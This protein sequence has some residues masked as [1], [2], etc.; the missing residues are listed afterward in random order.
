MNAE[1][2]YKEAISHGKYSE[3]IKSL[4]GKYD[5]VRLMWEDMLTGFYLRPYLETLVEEK[6]KAGNG[7][8]R[9][10]DL[11]CG[12]GDGYFLLS[13]LPKKSRLSDH[14]TRLI[15]EELVEHYKGVD[16]SIDLLKQAE[17]LFGRYDNVDF[18]KGDFSCGLPVEE[19]EPPYDL[20]F[21][22]YGTF[23]H[24]SDEELETLLVDIARHA[25]DGSIIV[26][27]W[28]GR[29][30]YEWQNLW[31]HDPAEQRYIDYK[32]NY[33]YDIED[34]DQV[35]VST[36]P[37][38]LMTP[39]EVA[40]IVERAAEKADVHLEIMRFFDRSLFV[41]RHIETG[42]YNDNPQPMRSMVSSLFEPGLRTYFPDLL[43]SYLPRE[44]FN[45]Q[46]RLLQNLAY[47]WNSLV[48]YT[49]KLA[50]YYDNPRKET[51]PQQPQTDFHVLNKAFKVMNLSF[52]AGKELL[53]DVRADFIEHQLGLALRS[54]EMG[55]QRGMGLGHGLV[56]I[57]RVSKEEGKR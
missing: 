11:G 18:V 28:L 17:T 49:M 12:T 29:Y 16:L 36:F 38:R 22:S 46:N 19:D 56:A 53:G 47:C 3:Q 25:H 13:H 45:W 30:S 54:L 52:E 23:S 48:Q 42:T 21:T 14:D 10:F 41:G 8:L 55:L 9:F 35:D 43:V 24:C 4:R 32:I 57:I 1:E 34:M 27:D 40:V 26:G 50:D 33:L 51:P 15:P 39:Q 31:V 44:G 37:M 7:G 5:H 2:A 6:R 20:Y